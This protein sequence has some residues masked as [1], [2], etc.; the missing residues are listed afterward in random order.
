MMVDGLRA[1]LLKTPVNITGIY[2]GFVATDMI[3]GN[4]FDTSE[5]VSPEEAGKIIVDGVLRGDEEII[6]P[7]KMNQLIGMISGMSPME[8]AQLVRQLMSENFFD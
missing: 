8:R 6:F 4:A 7:E 2:P 5:S 3:K 1:E